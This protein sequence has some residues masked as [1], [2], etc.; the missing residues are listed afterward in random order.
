[1]TRL[2][3]APTALAIVLSV[4]GAA[5]H[6]SAL[7]Q[8]DADAAASRAEL[9]EVQARRKE[10]EAAAADTEKLRAEADAAL[11]AVE[12]S[13][14]RAK[15]RLRELR[16]AQADVE[17]SLRAVRADQARTQADID[18]G[19]EALGQWLKRYYQHGGEPGVGHLL[20][21]RDPNQLARDAYYLERIGREKQAIVERL[22][23]AEARFAEQAS[24][25]ESKQKALEAN[26]RKQ[27]AQAAELKKEQARRAAILADLSSTLKAQH[28]Q[29][30]ELKHDESRLMALIRRIETAPPPRPNIPRESPT[31]EPEVGDSGRAADA[32]SRGKSFAR[33]RGQLHVPVEGRLIGR[34]GEARASTGTNWKGVFI[35]SRAGE[36]VRAVADGEVVYSDW[37]RGFGNLVIVDHGDNYLTVYGNNEA[38]F[39]STGERVQA[40]DVIAS[41]GDSGGIPESGLYF[42]IRHE[43]R[44]V[45][46]LTWIRRD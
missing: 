24:Q 33:L 21:A 35:R 42:E 23:V 27:Q 19:R 41:V 2:L 36:D 28:A 45:D 6:V 30:G 32:S 43:G 17:A 16:K 26:E 40:G 13:V 11:K 1:V 29:I 37:L 4:A 22:R 46:P 34:F 15:R 3:A 12:K 25:I 7:A 5:F 10:I 44:P 39:K 31:A 9:D 14:S 20:S 18:A 38:L 8:A